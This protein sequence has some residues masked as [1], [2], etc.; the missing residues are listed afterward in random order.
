M[1]LPLLLGFAAYAV[2]PTLPPE[3]PI[4]GR[5]P[6]APAVVAHWVDQQGN[7]ERQ[8]GGGVR[9]AWRWLN[10]PPQKRKSPLEPE[11]ASLP[12]G[13][14][15]IEVLFDTRALPPD[16]R[17]VSSRGTSGE[18]VSADLDPS[19]HA[20]GDPR[21]RHVVA[22]L[23]SELASVDLEFASSTGVQRATLVLSVP[24]AKPFVMR[25]RSC[26]DF[27]LQPPTDSQESLDGSHLYVGLSCDEDLH[28]NFLYFHFKRSDDAR[29]AYSGMK[30]ERE[31]DPYY[32]FKLD[33]DSKDLVDYKPILKLRTRDE[34]G[35][36]SE[37]ELRC[38][39]NA[40][41]C[42]RHHELPHKTY[43]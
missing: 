32:V 39:P 7:Y 16:W 21:L 43:F 11:D 31:R 28:D 18:V 41:S 6:S 27:A 29:W 38:I 22:R 24:E 20:T 25:H 5:L 37:L 12:W 34:W 30:A 9:S 10:A 14:P 1:L 26:A 17:L 33:K 13:T 40:P 3:V 42:R 4:A 2:E 8:R 23:H 35:R 36:L 15:Y 19:A